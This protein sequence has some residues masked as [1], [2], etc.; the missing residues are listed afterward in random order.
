MLSIISF[1][2]W[3]LH[4]DGKSAII[5]NIVIAQKNKNIKNPTSDALDFV[6]LALLEASEKQFQ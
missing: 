6:K 2:L 5:N 1:L 3:Y 4:F